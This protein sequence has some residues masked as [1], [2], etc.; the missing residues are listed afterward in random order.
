MG[1]EI[2]PAVNSTVEEKQK[3]FVFLLHLQKSRSYMRDRIVPSM[4]K[5][6]F[7]LYL[8]SK[9]PLALQKAHPQTMLPFHLY[10]PRLQLP[11]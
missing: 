8:D 1:K 9:K 5:G 4:L 7:P 3:Q 6:R 2:S 10:S 11:T